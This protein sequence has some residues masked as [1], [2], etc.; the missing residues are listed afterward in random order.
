[1][2]SEVN[3]ETEAAVMRALAKDREKRFAGCAEMAKA[4]LVPSGTSSDRPSKPLDKPSRVS[5]V[6]VAV[7]A[8]STLVSIGGWIVAHGEKERLKSANSPVSQED[9]SLGKGVR[10]LEEGLA[11]GKKTAELEAANENL[12][13]ELQDARSARERAEKDVQDLNE[14]LAAGGQSDK[15]TV[16]KLQKEL[17]D[18]KAA[19]AKAVKEVTDLKQQVELKERGLAKKPTESPAKPTIRIPA[20]GIAEIA[21]HLSLAKEYRERGAYDEALSE[22]S[23]AN[24]LD[25]TN[26]EVAAEIDRTKRACNAEKRLG[27]RDL[28]C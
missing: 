16:A 25:S 10:N 14:K 7:L 15:T 8:L 6:A 9:G 5:K 24:A 4:L 28:K 1:L 23:A 20:K 21:K 18:T 2:N 19:H 26:N 13:K 22:L 12:R 17:Q 3:K 27:G 11:A